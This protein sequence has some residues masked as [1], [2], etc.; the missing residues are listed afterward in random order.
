[1][2]KGAVPLLVTLLRSGKS[3]VQEQAASTLGNLAFWSRENKDAIAAAGAV[4]VL[5][6]FLKS[7]QPAL[8]EIGAWALVNFAPDSEHY[9]F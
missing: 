7:D 8:Q 9:Q 2:A 1:M 4:P 5:V 3:A 6:A